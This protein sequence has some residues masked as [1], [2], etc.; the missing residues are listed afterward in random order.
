MTARKCSIEN[1]PTANITSAATIKCFYC[2]GQYHLP[3]YDIITA[4][5]RIFVNKNVVFLC[6]E[7]IEP[8]DRSPEK[9][10]K[11]PTQST[12]FGGNGEMQ[13]SRSSSTSSLVNIGSQNTEKSTGKA[14]TATLANK[15]DKQT[16]ILA[17]LV[18]K[19]NAMKDAMAEQNTTTNEHIKQCTSAIENG[20][21]DYRSVPP[22]QSTTTTTATTLAKHSMEST[23]SSSLAAAPPVRTLDAATKQA[24]KNRTLIAGSNN[25]TGHG[26]GNAV[27]IGKR[28]LVVRGTE[29]N[30]LPKSIYVSRLETTITSDDISTYIKTRLPDI[31]S[32]HFSLRMLVKKDKPLETLT[33]ISFRLSC[34]NDLFNTF[35]SSS[36]WPDHVM[37]GEFFDKQPEKQRSVGNFIANK[38]DQLQNNAANDLS[39]EAKNDLHQHQTQ[40]PSQQPIQQPLQ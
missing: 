22:S 2:N 15:I 33:F 16:G 25:N 32:Q 36:F 5:N 17:E 3:C 37:I 1:C 9:K 4:A 7:C 29:H 8:S 27:Q 21:H 6:D 19:I 18:K 35:M 31:D 28:P 23:S 40:N 24:V 12:L 26:L 14:T 11:N 10:R 20:N 13:L 34:T 39:T 38:T 30:A